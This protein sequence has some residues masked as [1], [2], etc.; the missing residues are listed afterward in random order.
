MSGRVYL[1]L[2]V[3]FVAVAAP[4]GLCGPGNGWSD[5]FFFPGPVIGTRQFRSVYL[6]RVPL[7]RFSRLTGRRV[8][9]QGSYRVR[10]F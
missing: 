2:I 5:G 3:R 6:T 4:A 1:L 8:H 10:A 9:I 7:S